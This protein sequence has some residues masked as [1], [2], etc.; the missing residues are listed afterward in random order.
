MVLGFGFIKLSITFFYRRLFVT[1][2]N[3]L[4]DWATKVAIVIVV[5]WT[6]S[7]FFGFLFSCGTHISAAW[8]SV[9]DD[10]M[11]CGAAINLDNALVVSDLMTDVMILCL[12]LPVVSLPSTE[13][14]Q[15]EPLSMTELDLETSHDNE[16]EADSHWYLGHRRCV[17]RALVDWFKNTALT[18]TSQLY[19]RLD[20]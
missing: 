19:H 1:A 6:V 3:T 11:Y 4:F 7:F 9:Q 20:N 2:K 12:P 15:R 8:G 10:V 14:D 18:K 17:S 5:L 13:F 16:P